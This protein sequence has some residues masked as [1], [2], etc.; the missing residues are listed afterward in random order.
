MLCGLL[1]IVYSSEMCCG[2]IAR[3]ETALDDIA[4]HIEVVAT[5]SWGTRQ[6]HLEMCSLLLRKSS[7]EIERNVI[8]KDV[9]T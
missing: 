2:N 8:N 7:I 9:K 3:K 1:R 4:V 5:K 6:A